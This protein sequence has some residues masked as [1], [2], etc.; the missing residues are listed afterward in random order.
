MYLDVYWCL[1]LDVLKCILMFLW[2]W[3]IVIKI[4]RLWGYEL[5]ILWL[6]SSWSDCQALQFSVENYTWK[7]CQCPHN[8][9]CF[10]FQCPGMTTCLL[11]S[12]FLTRVSLFDK[13][14]H[15]KGKRLNCLFFS[16]EEGIFVWL[17][18]MMI[19]TDKSKSSTHV[20]TCIFCL[21]H[22][23]CDQGSYQSDFLK[24]LWKYFSQ[25][26]PTRGQVQESSI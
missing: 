24:E 17:G 22:C 5:C 8:S 12:P 25:F 7:A 26:R 1:K 19:F 18:M 10:A 11:L 3:C 14:N 16:K 9:T 21:G 13:Q 6:A 15:S 23:C 20:H 2:V 4:L